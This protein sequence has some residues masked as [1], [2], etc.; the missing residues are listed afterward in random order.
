VWSFCSSHGDSTPVEA[1]KINAE[2]CLAINHQCHDDKVM[3]FDYSIRVK[4]G[5]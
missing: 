1:H 2:F 3:D 5:G 4:D